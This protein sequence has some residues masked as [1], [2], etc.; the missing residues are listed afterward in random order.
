MTWFIH[1]SAQ[2][3][4]WKLSTV[5]QPNPKTKDKDHVSYSSDHKPNWCVIDFRIGSFIEKFCTRHGLHFQ[6]FRLIP[7]ISANLRA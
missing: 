6:F 7:G 3:K 2:P 5:H 4:N 1:L